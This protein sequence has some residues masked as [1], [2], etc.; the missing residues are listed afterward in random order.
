M[1]EQEKELLVLNENTD[2]LMRTH[3]EL[4]EMQ[5]VLEKV[6]GDEIEYSFLGQVMVE[7]ACRKLSAGHQLAI[8]RSS[9]CCQEAIRRPSEGHQ[10]AIR[11][12][13]GGRQTAMS[14]L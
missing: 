10:R 3:A 6:G 9:A 13:S 8:S 11:G 12:P 14:R 1:E 7:L 5:L 2:R 4:T